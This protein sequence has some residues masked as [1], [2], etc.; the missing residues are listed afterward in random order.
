MELPSAVGGMS[1]LQQEPQRLKDEAAQLQAT[2]EALY[3]ENYVVF[4]E[5]HECMAF[6]ENRG[7]DFYA[8]LASLQ[9]ELEG[10]KTDCQAF[11]KGAHEIVVDLKRNRQT[12]QHHLQVCMSCL[13][14]D[15]Y[16]VCEGSARS[17]MNCLSSSSS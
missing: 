11:Q 7:H 4:I 13:S 12:L 17:K 5:N 16:A 10:F 1:S 15:P 6:L 2:L 3:R 14:S 9:K 8:D